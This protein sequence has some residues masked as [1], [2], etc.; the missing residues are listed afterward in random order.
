MSNDLDLNYILFYLSVKLRGRRGRAH[1]HAHNELPH[2]VSGVGGG[3]PLV[4]GQT[5]NR[6]RVGGWLTLAGAEGSK[7]RASGGGMG[8]GARRDAK[9]RGT[10]GSWISSKGSSSRRA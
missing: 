6:R 7:A 2:V 5:M 9:P 8:A 1:T 10:L 4:G 3:E